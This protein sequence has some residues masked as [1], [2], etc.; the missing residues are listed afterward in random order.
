MS[1][2]GDEASLLVVPDAGP[3][4]TLAY[5]DALDLLHAAGGAVGIVDM[6]RHE[7]T[8]TRTPTSERIGAWI[9]ARADRLITTEVFARYRER[10]DA[11]GTSPRKANLGELAAQEAMNALAVRSPPERAVFLFEDHRLARTGFVLPDG[12]S[13]ATTRAWLRFLERSGRIASAVEV[14]R[15]ALAAGRAFSA[16]RFP[17]EP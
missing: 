9:D 6:V 8:R 7:V 16:L 17:D 3:L 2:T 12:C 5:A 11:P 1:N 14:E 10:L 15:R 13:K 4:I